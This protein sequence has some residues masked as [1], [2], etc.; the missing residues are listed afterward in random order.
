[1]T[2]RKRAPR[3][4]SDGLGENI[5]VVLEDM[6]AQ[7]QVVIE[8][9]QAL[10]RKLESEIGNLRTELVE[11]LDRL[12]ATVAQHSR[13]LAAMRRELREAATAA[14]LAALEQRVAA[15]ERRLGN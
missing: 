6:R 7:N 14:A 9:V 10:D 13:D 8:A 1:M 12:E 4:R 2:A 3:R 15:I 11:R 5:L